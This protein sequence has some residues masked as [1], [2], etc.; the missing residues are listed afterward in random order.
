MTDPM[1]QSAVRPLNKDESGVLM[2]VV[3]V[4]GDI[5]EQGLKGSFGVARA[6]RSELF[7]AT[8]GAVDWVESVQQVP[9]KVV[10]EAI[11]RADKLSSDAV[12]GVESVTMAVTSAVRGSGE[13]AGEMVSR[14][15]DALVGVKSR[16]VHVA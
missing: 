2:T 6:L 3:T 14:T 15:A 12:D 8:Q 1:M 9:F 4:A 16:P 7:R 11:Q 13:A 5:T 10:R